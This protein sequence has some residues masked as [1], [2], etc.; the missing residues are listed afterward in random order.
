MNHAH[1][2]NEARKLRRWFVHGVTTV[3]FLLASIGLIYGL[4]SILLPIIMALFLAYIFKPL[5]RFFRIS[6]WISYI[7]LS[8][9]LGTTVLC[10]YA[11]SIA[12]KNALPNE[13][14]KVVLKVRL[15][16][17][18][19]H[20]LDSFLGKEESAKG[21]FIYENF[22]PEI[23]PL[24]AQINNFLTLNS[25]ENSLFLRHMKSLSVSNPVAAQKYTE[26]FNI[27]IQNLV[28]EKMIPQAYNEADP[29][30]H[31]DA[32]LM[33][34]SKPKNAMSNLF[35]VASHW[36][37]F[38]FIFIFA[39]LDNGQMLHFFMRLVPNRYFELTYSVVNNVDEA[40]GKYIRGTFIEC[41]LVGVSL[42][43]GF[44]LC[45][46]DFQVAFLIGV[47]GG[48]T[49]AIPF[50]GTGI[51][52]AL[53]AAYALI[54]ENIE[55]VLPFITLDN[56]MFVMIGVVMVVHL[57]D[58]AVFQPLIVGKLVNLHPLVVV[59][60]VFGGSIIFGFAGLLLA[61]PS[62]VVMLVVFKTFF[63][64]LSKYKIV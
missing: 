9:F 39:L 6:N 23:E 30:H 47:I 45:G 8:V 50:V 15:Q 53:S 3:L 21:N 42:I 1:E 2:K 35:K 25:K 59:L 17:Q 11:I 58:N 10:F 56:L 5:T 43:L 57:I 46:F 14:E 13:A 37:I 63:T 16:Y 40:L 48:L 29:T 44:Y 7:K 34:L 26:Y 55:P 18:L 31:P 54:A 27:N 19:N 4:Q 28:E 12:A 24:R 41:A 38:P 61:I 22:G 20:R 32:Q 36:I 49:N 64:G 62:V 60:A 52:C 33:P 51:A